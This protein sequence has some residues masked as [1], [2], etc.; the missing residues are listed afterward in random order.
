[1]SHPAD[2]L[3]YSEE[4]LSDLHRQLFA[5]RITEAQRAELMELM[6]Y[7]VWLL[8]QPAPLHYM[9]AYG[10]LVGAL[11]FEGI[12]PWDDDIDL[13]CLQQDYAA[14][15]E[16]CLASGKLGWIDL[17]YGTQGGV[18]GYSKVWF[19]G[20]RR[21]HQ[22]DSPW[23]WPFL[24]LFW[25]GET[26]EGQ[27]QNISWEQTFPREAILPVRLERFE[28]QR[29]ACPGQAERVVRQIYPDALTHGIPPIYDHFQEQ[30]IFV[31]LRFERVPLEQL[32]PTYPVLS[33]T[34]PRL[35]A[36]RKAAP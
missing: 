28:G 6:S 8:A 19:K 33:Q 25:L 3:P 18:D 29:L 35:A 27:L 21:Y 26:A 5:P 9:L 31:E 34:L 17:P 30:D 13:F 32:I 22:W 23:G 14:I 12:I 20:A 16:R 7:F 36:F 2:P 11:V 4:T 24:D 10:S 1:M 15:K